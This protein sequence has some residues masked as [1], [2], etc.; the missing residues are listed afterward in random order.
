MYLALLDNAY[1]SGPQHVP[2]IGE[3][4]LIF[5]S[6]Y[7]GDVVPDTDAVRNVIGVTF[8]RERRY[9]EA[10]AAFREALARNANSIDANR[11]LA[12]ALA[13]TGHVSEALGYLRQAVR[14]DPRNGTL[15]YELGRLLLDRRQF[16]EASACFRA[17]LQSMPDSSSLHNDLG[18]ALAS[19]GDFLDAIEQFRQAVALDP[20]FNEA[21][22]NLASAERASAGS[23]AGSARS[24]S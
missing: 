18:V 10:M 11:N 1:R 9:E 16:G 21:R 15:Q 14:L 19:S 20:S 22:R 24:S 8:L 7:L 13:D 17:A 4:R 2:S 23:S 12:T 6:R 5:G 3:P